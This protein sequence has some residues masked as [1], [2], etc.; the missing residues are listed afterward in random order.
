MADNMNGLDS[1]W[2]PFLNREPGANLMLFVCPN[3][4]DGL[5]LLALVVGGAT[6]RTG[7]ECSVSSASSV[8]NKWIASGVR[9][10]RYG[11]E[12]FPL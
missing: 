2:S 1:C 8:V 9:V 10:S 7:A 3:L 12:D 11:L 5:L 6:K 4:D